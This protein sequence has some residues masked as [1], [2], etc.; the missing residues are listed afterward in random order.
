MHCTCGL[1]FDLSEERCLIKNQEKSQWILKM[2]AYVQRQVQ[3]TFGLS[4]IIRYCKY[5]CCLL[6]PKCSAPFLEE[7][8]TFGA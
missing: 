3:R 5:L 7:Q 1:P 8:H 2:Q 4:M 6:I